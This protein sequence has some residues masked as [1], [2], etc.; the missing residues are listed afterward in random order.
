MVLC[1]SESSLGTSPHTLSIVDQ[2]LDQLRAMV[3]EMGGRVETA[4]DDAVGALV[5][6]DQTRAAGVVAGDVKVDALA[7]RI[8]RSA[9]ELIALRTP[10]AD[11]LREVLSAFKIANLIARMGDCAKNVAHRAMILGDLHA[12]DQ[13]RSFA[14]MNEAVSAML[15]AAL[16][17]FST[18]NA[19]AA[20]RVRDMD[21]EVDAFHSGIFHA[22]VEHMTRHPESITAASHLLYVSGKLERIG[23]HAA[24]IADMVHYAVTGASAGVPDPSPQRLSA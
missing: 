1:A 16:D 11:D 18:R 12:I 15:K 6:G 24:A 5:M 20:A 22:L 3:C 19:P 7:Q 4:L 9:I 10:L 14:R 8:E 23:D 21:E 17:A 2:D 13:L